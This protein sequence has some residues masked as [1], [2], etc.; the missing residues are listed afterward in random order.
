MSFNDR[1]MSAGRRYGVAPSVPR[2]G[3]GNKGVLSGGNYTHCIPGGSPTPCF[4]SGP[5]PHS[6]II[7]RPGGRGR[8]GN[9]RLF[10]DDAAVFVEQEGEYG[11]SFFVSGVGA[12][13]VLN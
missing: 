5:R 8:R 10:F 13:A 6:S 1:L 4:Y 12:A 7:F 9:R 11:M 3:G 2:A